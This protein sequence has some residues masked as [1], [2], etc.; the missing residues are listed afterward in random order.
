MKCTILLQ[1]PCVLCAEMLVLLITGVPQL[2]PQTD[3]GKKLLR[4]DSCLDYIA[5]GGKTAV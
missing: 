4:S 2:V 3:G 5:P 1:L